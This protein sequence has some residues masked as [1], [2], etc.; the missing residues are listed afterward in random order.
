MK[1]RIAKNVLQ[2]CLTNLSGQSVLE[3]HQYEDGIRIPY[4]MNDVIECYILLGGA[5]VTGELTKTPAKG[6]SAEAIRDGERGAVIVR[7]PADARG[8]SEIFTIWYEGEA[9]LVIDCYQYHRIMH[10]W[11]KDAPHLRNQ[12]G[13]ISN[14][15]D[16][17]HFI[18]EF[19]CEQ[20]E[21]ELCDLILFGPFRA[22]SPV[23]G[24]L[25]EFYPESEAGAQAMLRV[26]QAAGDRSYAALTRRYMAHPTK[27]L[28]GF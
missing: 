23:K 3:F 17:R 8:R 24:S 28:R 26:A 27:L 9:W 13:I 4:L 15:Y 19:V 21:L 1:R 10:Y 5:R 22:Y 2:Y 20:E 12:V 14:L 18:G 16:K 11:R 6:T 7:T 25:D